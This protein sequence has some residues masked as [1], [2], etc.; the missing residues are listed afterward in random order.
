MKQQSFAGQGSLG[1]LDEADTAYLDAVMQIWASTAIYTASPVVDT[2]L[3]RLGWPAADASFVDPSC[4]DGMFLGRALERLLAGQPPGFNPVGRIE[5]W[6]LFEGAVIEARVRVAGILTA[7]GHTAG[8]AARIAGEMVKH[9]DFITAGPKTPTWT[10]C[11]G[12]PPYLRYANVPDII[13]QAHR[14][15]VPGYAIADMLHSFLERIARV[16]IPGGQIGLVTSDRWLINDQAAGLREALGRFLSLTHHERLSVESSFYRPKTRRRDSLPRIHPVLVTF[17]TDLKQ[18]VKLTSAPHYPGV[19]ASV[20]SGIP[21]LGDFAKVR[22]APWLGT[23]GIFVVDAR[24]ASGL[25]SEYLVPAVDT[26]DF[27][28]GNLG[29]P[30]RWA[31]RTLPDEEPPAEIM[32]HL[33]SQ[34]HRMAKRGLNGKFWMP[35]ESWHNMDLSRES[36][37]VPRIAKAPRA[38][39][40]PAGC[41][42]INHNLSIVSGSEEQ[43]AAVEAALADPLA[44]QWVRE[45]AAPLENG[46][47]SLTTQL[48]RKLPMAHAAAP[49]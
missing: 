29:T 22:L 46:Y 1:F 30:T 37:L 39:R 43:L 2:I 44:L 27:Q 21:T 23:K 24:V 6:E 36:L 32:Q 28:N 13:R 42:P 40:V 18:G 41:L 15:H 3:D 7:H 19:D 9:G 38:I 8:A 14:R 25:P 10:I 47:F 4:G 33:E 48:L 34:M 31:I 5:G 12:N 45:H 49:A 16:V 26:D 17:S 11:A 35:P 20:Y